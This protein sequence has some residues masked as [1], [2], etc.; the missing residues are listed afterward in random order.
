MDSITEASK[1]C[2]TVH[3]QKVLIVFAATFIQYVKRPNQLALPAVQHL[4]FHR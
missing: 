1:H 2:W 3:K 4:D